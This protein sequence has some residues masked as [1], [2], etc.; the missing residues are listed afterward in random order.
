MKVDHLSTY[1]NGGAA[2]AA[3]RLHDSLINLKID[4]NFFYSQAITVFCQETVPPDRT[5]IPLYKNTSHIAKFY[6]A[7]RRRLYPIGAIRA[8]NT[9]RPGYERFRS[10]ILYNKS[11]ISMLSHMPNIL[12]L[13]WI[14]EFLDHPSFFAS[15]PDTL[16]IVWTLHD[17]TPFTGGCNY[18]WNCQHFKTVCHDCPQLNINS[19]NDFARK[20]FEVKRYAIK[21]K[22]IHVVANS[23]LIES[24]A[25]QSP[26]FSNVKSFQTIHYG[27]DIGI[28]KP[29]EKTAARK[30]L[31]IES[32]K[33][34]LSFGAVSLSNKRKGMK[35]FISAI[36]KLENKEHI[37]VL[38]FGGGEKIQKI[39]GVEIINAGYQNSPEALST[40]YSASDVF[41]IPSLQEAFGQTS[42]EAMACGTPVVGFNTGGISD[43]IIP[44]ETG[45][46][47]KTGDSE[48]LAKK[49]QWM[50]SHPIERSA[51]GKK[52][53]KLVEE[54]FTLEKQAESYLS[55]YKNILD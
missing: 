13:H 51:M 11:S 34:I 15:V 43:M 29:K 12:Q 2:I 41:V 20:C 42:L 9:R 8:M 31:N 28:F 37:L 38:T 26:I 54:E 14:Y 27:L 25:R 18:N 55:L 48:D 23:T 4:S 44:G 40:I 7:I 6:R 17:M 16:P 30:E 36:R 19:S 46:M 52:A 45:L 53:R 39:P 50:V 21:N 49:I 22:N 1:L 10:P 35:E 24:E 47:A 33:T 32:N 5:Y 3:R